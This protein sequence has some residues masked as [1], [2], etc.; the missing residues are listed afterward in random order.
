VA[1]QAGG[2]LR[3]ERPDEG[4]VV[5]GAEAVGEREFLGDVDGDAARIALA[6]DLRQPRPLVRLAFGLP[7]AVKL[8]A[9]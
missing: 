9:G 3:P 1:D 5:A 2:K 4:L 8:P 6:D 7:G